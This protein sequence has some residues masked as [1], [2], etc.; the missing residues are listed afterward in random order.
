MEFNHERP[1]YQQ[2]KEELAR[3]IARGELPP[4]SK[5]PAVRETAQR[6]QVNPN[7]VQRAYRELEGEGLFFTR[8]GQGTFVT[9]DEAAVSSLRRDLAREGARSFVKLGLSL[10]LER[11]EL[12]KLLREAMEREGI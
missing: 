2:I 5:V 7:T 10:G 1:I 6:M 11:E 8:R 12:K 4:G 3:M 9:E